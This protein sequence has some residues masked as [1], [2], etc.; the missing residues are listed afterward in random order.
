MRNPCRLQRS[1]HLYT[2]KLRRMSNDFASIHR[3]VL[4]K[5]REACFAPIDAQLREP[6]ACEG[7]RLVH[8]VASTHPSA[9]QT[10][11]HFCPFRF[12]KNNFLKIEASA[13]SKHDQWAGFLKTFALFLSSVDIETNYGT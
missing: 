5:T 9:S 2:G 4:P 1:I 11:P 13:Q 3:K 8:A 10:V 7:A 6:L 12:Q